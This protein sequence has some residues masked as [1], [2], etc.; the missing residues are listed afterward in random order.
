M[1]MREDLP[2]DEQIE[3]ACRDLF[4]C[5]RLIAEV[6]H[7]CPYCLLFTLANMTRDALEDGR[8]QHEQPETLQ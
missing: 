4:Q 3:D 1:T 5:L 8:I 2:S 7:M 6:N